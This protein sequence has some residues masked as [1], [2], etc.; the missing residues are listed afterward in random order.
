MEKIK[1]N[2]IL[3]VIYILLLVLILALIWKFG[4][5]SQEK[6]EKVG[7][8]TTGDMTY[9]GWSAVNYQ[10]VENACKNLD[11][12]LLAAFDVAEYDG[13]CPDQ[14]EYLVQE[15]AGLIILN[16]YG[17]T[18]EMKD[19]LADF[20]NTV[21]YGSSADYEAPNLTSYS[22]R[23]YQVRYLSGIVA[24]M[25]TKSGKIGF[26]AADKENAVYRGINAFA[27]GV[28]RVNPDAEIIV[29]LTGNWDDKEKE[30]DLAKAM[31]EKEHVDLLTY[32]QNHPHVIDVAEEYGIASIGY[33]EPVENASDKY[34]TCAMCD[35]TPVYEGIIREYLRGQGNSVKSDWLGLESGVIHLTEYS[36]LV[37]KEARDE[38]EK[39]RQEILAG[40]D[41]FTGTIYDNQG[42]KRC[43]TGEAMSDE[44]LLYNMDWL[45]EGVSIYED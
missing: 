29:A 31:I 21:F 3:A 44:A 1:R 42:K 12:E 33:Y 35:W 36:P 8:I 24:G 15:G 20:P 41:V 17:F 16:S 13:S 6:P 19:L 30:M 11:V 27:L 22:S 2:Y 7:F 38:V 4:A 25:Q 28:R 10:G 34:L 32:H 26:V 18:V 39:A 37:S 40:Q 43:S 9:T 5:P 45:A 14:V 23:L